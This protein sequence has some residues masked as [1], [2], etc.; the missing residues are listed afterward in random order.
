MKRLLTVLLLAAVSPLAAAAQ[1]GLGLADVVLRLQQLESE[2]RQ[3]RGEVEMQKHA[4][5]ALKR[6]QRD[7]YMDLDSRLGGGGAPATGAGAASGPA[8]VAV[9]SREQ[10]PPVDSAPAPTAEPRP[11]AAP[12]TASSATP[13]DPAREKAEYQEAF[14]LLRNGRYSDSIVAFRSFLATYP[15]G[16]YADN[17]LY[18]LGEASYVS[19]DFTTALGDFNQLLQQHPASPKVPGAML[20]I[21]YIHYEQRGWAK[22]RKVLKRLLKEHPG[23]TE[24]QLAQ[25]RLS[26][27]RK[28]GH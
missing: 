24:A 14:G 1:Q 23:S 5:D 22:A 4:I 27:M 3:L 28:E 8:A 17:A 2:V 9:E 26:R 12:P 20:K 16:D 13:G 7:L 10:P 11:P 25:Q 18:W 6:R 21:G 15:N 19:R